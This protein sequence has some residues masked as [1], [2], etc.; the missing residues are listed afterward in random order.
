MPHVR[1]GTVVTSQ[2]FALIV[3]W[4]ALCVSGC[5][6]RSRWAIDDPVYA[7]KYADATQTP[8]RKVKQAFDARHVEGGGGT[9]VAVAG[10]DQPATLGGSIGL[11]A[12]PKSWLEVQGGL[13]G[14]LGSGAEDALGGLNIGLRLNTPTRVAPFAGVGAAVAWSKR[15]ASNDSVDNDHDFLIDEFDEEE[16]NVLGAIY[17]EVGL[18]YW[19]N[20]RL[21]LTGGA[22]YFVTSE[23]RDYDFWYYGLSLSIFGGGQPHPRFD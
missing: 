3:M 18:H 7:A 21:R 8:G 11:F 19:L 15:D 13:T 23:G 20:H 1:F 4:A 9:Y 17:P 14:L 6:L 16:S 12:F 10:A 2:V 5:N 22:S